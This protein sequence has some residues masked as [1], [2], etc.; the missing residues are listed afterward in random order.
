MLNRDESKRIKKDRAWK[1]QAQESKCGLIN[2]RP[3]RFQPREMPQLKGTFIRM[4]QVTPPPL[5]DR[6]WIFCFLIYISDLT[7]DWGWSP[8]YTPALCRPWVFCMEGPFSML[9][10]VLVPLGFPPLLP[11]SQEVSAFVFTSH[12]LFNMRLIFW[13]LGISIAF[14]WAQK[15]P[16]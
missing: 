1:V 3:H 16:F 7:L 10:S 12:S 6:R 11:A 14:C 2:T 5:S 15:W 8:I 9:P 13:S 4:R